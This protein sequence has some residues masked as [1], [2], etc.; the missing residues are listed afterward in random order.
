M[1]ILER[2]LY[3]QFSEARNNQSGTNCNSS[4]ASGNNSD[5]TG[6]CNS[7]DEL[8][9]FPP[10]EDADYIPHLV[11]QRR[12]AKIPERLI[13][14]TCL[15]S[16]HRFV[17]ASDVIPR[18]LRDRRR[19]YLEDS[20][21]NGGNNVNPPRRKWRTDG[22]V[23]QRYD[24]IMHATSY[25]SSS[26]SSSNSKMEDDETADDNSGVWAS[27]GINNLA[28]SASLYGN[29]HQAY[30]VEQSASYPNTSRRGMLFYV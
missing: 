27:R 12:H 3:S 28:P 11:N 2:D 5:S 16:G 24:V 23:S 1:E 17:F 13:N 20:F 10:D 26:S 22:N 30:H 25:D 9:I 18:P 6:K 8:R 19:K 21:A 7:L 29:E 15:N 14:T 4:S